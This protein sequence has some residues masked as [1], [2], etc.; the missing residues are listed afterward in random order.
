MWVYDD[1]RLLWKR[2]LHGTGGSQEAFGD[3]PPTTAL[4]EQ[5]LTPAGIGLLRSVVVSAMT[6]TIEISNDA[7]VGWNQPGVL[8]GATNVR[9]DD[10]RL[11]FVAWDDARLPGRLADPWSWLPASAWQD[12]RRN[13]FVPAKYGVCVEDFATIGV[14]AAEVGRVLERLPGPTI[15]L[16]QSRGTAPGAAATDA[17]CAIVVTTSDA[18]LVVATLQE[19]GVREDP[20][21]A[22]RYRL[23]EQLMVELLPIVPSGEPVCNCG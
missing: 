20:D 22:L 9:L 19:A 1:G 18:R 8:W 23:D 12:L 15:D 11:A 21:A 3:V 10:G 2:E 7:M 5:R 17:R 14:N 4:I 16:L 6:G 13:G